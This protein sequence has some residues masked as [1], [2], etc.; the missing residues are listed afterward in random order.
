VN[1]EPLSITEDPI[2]PPDDLLNVDLFV[3]AGS[4]VS[5]QEEP[6]AFDAMNTVTNK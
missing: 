5:S 3:S 4:G 2:D 1:I 6:P